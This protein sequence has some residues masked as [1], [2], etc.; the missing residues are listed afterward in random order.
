MSDG[1]YIRA[2]TVKSDDAVFDAMRWRSPMAIFAD[3]L[4]AAEH[5]GMEYPNAMTLATVDSTGMPQARIVLLKTFAAGDEVF[6]FFTHRDGRKGK[7]L[8]TCPKAALTFYWPPLSRQVLVEGVVH[9][10]PREE[11]AVYY[12]TRPRQ[13]RI[14]AWASRQSQPVE[15]YAVFRAQ[16]AAEEKKYANKKPPLPPHWTGFM[17]VPLR[18]E[19][20]QDGHCRLHQRLVFERASS[21][22]PWQSMF[23]QP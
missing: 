22:Q 6:K 17:L 10:L 3:W 9:E 18:L 15:S 1:N 20:W 13:S 12:H 21:A 16:V 7:A 2:A 23:L 4:V 11:T 5:T 19:F 8:Q 14:G